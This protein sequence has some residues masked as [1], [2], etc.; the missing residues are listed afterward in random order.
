MPFLKVYRW[1]FNINILFHDCLYLID[2]EN[3]FN[4]HIMARFRFFTSNELSAKLVIR[5]RDY[6]NYGQCG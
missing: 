4:V 6:E 3:Y 5:D 2:N 1:C